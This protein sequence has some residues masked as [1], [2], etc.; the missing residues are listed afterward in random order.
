MPFF[1]SVSGSKGG[2]L[3]K[4][5]NVAPPVAVMSATT[6]FNQ[7]RAT[8]N[9]TVTSIG[10]PASVKFQ[11]STNGTTWT[12]GETISNI[13]GIAQSVYSNQTG[14]SV[15]T[16]YYVR[17]V[18]TNANSSVTPLLNNTFTTWSLQVYE[19]TATG[20][21]TFTI[22][23]IT[24]T[25]GTEIAVS[26]YD[27]IM[28]GGGGG[29]VNYGGG[30]GAYISDSS[31]QLT[32]NRSITT[33]VGSAGYWSTNPYAAINATASTI[34]GAIT[35]YTAAGGT[36]D[37]NGQ[38][39]NGYS[40]GTFA[41]YNAQPG[42]AK[43]PDY[44]ND[45]YGGGGGAGGAGGA[46]SAGSWG[47]TGGNGGPG[48]SITRGGV[49][50]E[51]GAGGGGGASASESGTSTRGSIGIYNTYGS[52]GRGQIS[53]DMTAGQNGYIRFRYYAVSALA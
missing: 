24:P 37:T 17:A 44:S 38:S 10:G 26:I 41:T 3:L 11:Y 36:T 32:G 52:G 43:S 25:G 33:N 27:T 34:S 15:G 1:S 42:S 16:L 9:A 5:S 46:G 35:T 18:V 4:L 47:A 53:G 2:F 40:G 28:F 6:N 45:G 13:T 49:T 29:G 7:D 22:P 20:G 21:V 19:R 12:D 50:I 51:G 48:V 23:T 30:G 8:F 31:R 14:L 39:G